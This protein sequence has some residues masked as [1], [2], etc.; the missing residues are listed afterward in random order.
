MGQSRALPIF[1]I[2]FS[3]IYVLSMYFNFAVFTYLPK[4]KTFH[5]FVFTPAAN[6]APGMYWYGWIVTSAVGAGLIAAA[7]SLAPPRLTARLP[8]PAIW[9]VPLVSILVV[10]Y[11]LREW[12]TH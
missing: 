12:F 7:A 4:D 9:I 8:A 1:T 5:P 6:L 10:I 2:A 3:I 11:I